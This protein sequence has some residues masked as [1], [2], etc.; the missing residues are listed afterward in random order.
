MIFFFTWEEKYLIDSKIEKWK[1]AFVQKY[2]SENIY[3]FWEWDFSVDRIQEVLLWWG[4]FDSKKFIIIKWAPKDTHTKI[5]SWELDKLF[6][7]ME[8]YMGSFD[9]DNVIVFTSYKPDKRTKFYKF[10]SKQEN[11]KLEEYK[12]FSEKKL[13][14]Y[15]EKTFGLTNT[16]ANY[17]I[18]KTWTNLFNIHNELEKILKVNDKITKE[19]VDKYVNVNIEQ[20]SFS[21]LDNLKNK[22]KI[23]NILHN[24]QTNKEDIF[25]ILWLLYWNIKNVI[26]VLEQKAF[27]Y[28][29][30]E[31][32][33]K[34]W[35][36]PFV[37]WKILKSNNNDT[38]LFE[39]VFKKLINLDYSIKSWKVD[40]SLWYLYLKKIFLDI[41]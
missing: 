16:L 20:D 14:A 24:L 27:G 29:S 15:L 31:I 36:H 10:L 6:S 9:N 13:I 37:V 12:L 41:N 25:K 30:K 18:Q 7:F 38:E 33:S 3:N 26:L 11:I 21:L 19:L 1:K 8:K 32:A 22:D 40:S 28:D 34:V 17:V 2:W 35:A 39:K 23:I 4:L 5:P